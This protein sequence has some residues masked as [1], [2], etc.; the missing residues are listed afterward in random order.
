[1][2]SSRE[3]LELEKLGLFHVLVH[4]LEIAQL[5]CNMVCT[6][7]DEYG[8]A[9]I[10]PSDCNTNIL[11]NTNL[12]HASTSYNDI[13]SPF[14]TLGGFCY[15]YD[16]EPHSSFNLCK[17]EKL[18][19]SQNSLSTLKTLGSIH[20]DRWTSTRWAIGNVGS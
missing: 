2:G 9:N 8:I 18:L 12:F 3:L 17:D 13:K 11:T 15:N 10:T 5:E 1:M 19:R 7:G 14:E 6:A 20:Y 4:R 16:E